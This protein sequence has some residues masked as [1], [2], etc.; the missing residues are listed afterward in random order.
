MRRAVVSLL[1]CVYVL[2]LSTA[3]G[4]AQTGFPD[5]CPNGAPLPFAAIG[6]THSVDQN[7]GI[8]GKSTS[9]SATQVQN[10]VK[11]NFC[12]VPANKTPET[13]TPQMLIDLQRNSHIP[14]GHGLEPTDRIRPRSLGE[15]KVIRMKAYLIEAHHADLGAGES[16]NCNGSSEEDNDIHI[17]FGAQPS[18]Q[19]CNSVTAEISPHHR[20]ASWNEIGHYEKW[21]PKTK[22]Y[23]PNPGVASRLQAHAYRITGQLFFDASHAPCPCGTAACNPVRA[24]VWEIHPVYNI[25][26]C[27]PGSSCDENT[28][29][30][31]MAFDTWWKSLAPPRP[32][33]PSHIH[34]LHES[35]STPKRPGRNAPEGG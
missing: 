15:G 13:F 35:K 4:L 32:P 18:T 1:S 12:S 14:S 10:A 3:S 17:A 21:N 26:V 27:K 22:K 34:Q 5:H 6:V 20:P 30:D 16:V 33:K 9:P 29:A 19:E 2:L 7:C 24:S 8:K 11:N 23:D 25:E 28:D 31:W